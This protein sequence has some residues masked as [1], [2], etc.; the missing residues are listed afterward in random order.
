MSLTCKS[1]RHQR[2]V[3]GR[4][5]ALTSTGFSV[6]ITCACGGTVVTGCNKNLNALNSC[7]VHLPLLPLLPHLPLTLALAQN[8]AAG[9]VCANPE[10]ND[11]DPNATA[12]PFFAPCAHDAYTYPDD[13][14]ANSYGTCGT[15]DIVCCIGP[16]CPA[17][18]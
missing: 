11:Q 6:S 12:T 8:P 14:A 1:C 5:T 4:L 18:P 3:E 17:H 7:P 9:G 13:Q 15:Q 10:R 2:S 16:D